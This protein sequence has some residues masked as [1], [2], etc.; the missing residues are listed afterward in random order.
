MIYRLLIGITMAAALI[1]GQQTAKEL[2]LGKARSLE[3]RGRMDLAAES[4]QQVLLADPNN[5]E[6]LAGLVRFERQAGRNQ[7]AERYQERLRRLD[8]RNASLARTDSVGLLAPHREKLQEASRL[9]SGQQFDEAMQIFKQVFGSNPPPGGWAVAYYETLAATSGG[10]EPAT[11]ALRRLVD[12]YPGVADYR[13]S[14]GRLLTYRPETRM[15]GLRLLEQVQG[16]SALKA[17]AKQSWRQALAWEG[18]NPAI[19]GSLRTYLNRYPDPELRIVLDRMEKVETSRGPVVSREEGLG[20]SALQAGRLEEAEA[21]FLAAQRETPNSSG[22]VAGIGFLRMKQE[23]FAAAKVSFEKALEL[24]P[25]DK[26]FT[27][28]LSTASFYLTMKN[29]AAS[30]AAGNAPEAVELY[31]SAM[32]TRPQDIDALKGYAGSL[33]KA[34]DYA[35]SAESYLRLTRIQAEDSEA[36]K[37]LFVA[38]Y[39]SKGGA[40]ALQEWS[41][42]PEK[43]QQTLS[44]NVQH[45]AILATAYSDIGQMEESQRLLQHAVDLTGMERRATA[46]PL[47]LQLAGMF[48]QQGKPVQAALVFQKVTDDNPNNIDAWEGLLG[49]LVRAKD[50]IRA[51]AALQRMPKS[52]YSLAITRPGFLRAAAHIQERAGYMDLAERLLEAARSASGTADSN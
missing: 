8:P 1:V 20:Y 37:N 30:H 27:D 4:W 48:L 5:L 42:S 26:V 13:F 43:V 44:R 52:V 45:L 22:A 46:I 11:A 38:R 19:L 33:M 25:N 29:A 14:L 31:R 16:D 12:Q 35:T 36:W 23:D 28:A 34:E 15:A 49:A 47:R 39:K 10:W 7:E 51:V 24:K 6:A 2:L 41:T 3:G 18:S 40:A 50:Q 21:H 17:K 32:E 9:A